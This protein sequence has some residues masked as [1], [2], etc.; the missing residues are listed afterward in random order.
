MAINVKVNPPLLRELR[1]LGVLS[2]DAAPLVSGPFRIKAESFAGDASGA[3]KTLAQTPLTSGV[4]GMFRVLSANTGTH[5]YETMAV[6]TDYTISGATL[7]YKSSHSYG[8]SI[9][10]FYAY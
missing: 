2:S 7:T 3:T 9:L 1:Q 10:V 8:Y 4:I 5:T 6:T